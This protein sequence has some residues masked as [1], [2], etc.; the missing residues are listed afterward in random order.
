MTSSDVNHY[1]V[2]QMM[3]DI[4]T[5]TERW[6]QKNKD[7]EIAHNHKHKLDVVKQLGVIECT[8]IILDRKTE[9]PIYRLDAG[10]HYSKDDDKV[11]FMGRSN[12]D[13]RHERRVCDVANKIDT[14]CLHQK[15]GS[16]AANYAPWHMKMEWNGWLNE[17]YPEFEEEQSVNN[18][19]NLTTEQL[20]E[21]VS[22]QLSNIRKEYMWQLTETV[23]KPEEFK[24]L[25]NKRLDKALREVLRVVEEIE[26]R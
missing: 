15:H 11:F 22:E 9:N 13:G 12:I 3:E 14:H 26:R 21:K 20:V 25:G 23:P 16:Y 24:Y 1:G 5:I 7:K 17:Y 18:I 19:D 8:L 2:F 4:I 6:V 10:Y